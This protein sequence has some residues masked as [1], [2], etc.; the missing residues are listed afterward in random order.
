MLNLKNAPFLLICLGAFLLL[1][2]GNGQCSGYFVSLTDTQGKAL[3]FTKP[4]RK[5]VCLFPAV[6]EMMVRFGKQETLVGLC[7]QDMLEHS[8]LTVKNLGSFFSPD[9]EAIAR[10]EPDLI[11]AFPSQKDVIQRVDSGDCPV[12]VMEIRSLDQSFSVMGDMGRLFD[13]EQKARDVIEENKNQIALVKARLTAEPE[14]KR[15]RVVR[16]MMGQAL[17]CPGDD[18]FQNEVIRAA[19]GIPPQ[20]GRN[21]FAVSVSPEEWTT[22]DPEFV[23]GCDRNQKAVEALL[24]K[25]P[26][27]RVAAVKNGSVSMFPCDLTCRATVRTGA[28]VQWFATTLYPDL[29]TDPHKAV[30]QDTFLSKQPLN[31]P[32]DYVKEASVVTHRVWDATYHSVLINLS[33]PMVVLS[34]FEGLR[35]GVRGVGNTHVPMHASLGHMMHGVDAVKPVIARNLGFKEKHYAGL[36]TGA[37]MDNLSIQTRTSGDL[38]V[39]LLVTAGVRGNALRV[40]EEFQAHDT[41]GTINVIVLTNRHLSPSAMA[42]AMVMVTEGKTAALSDMDIRS[43]RTP[44]EHQATGT[45]TDTILVVEGQ[46][47]EILWAGGHTAMG[48]MIAGAAYD[49]VVEAIFKQ[50]GIRKNR[51]ILQRLDERKLTLENLAGMFDA[52]MEKTMLAG[53]LETLLAQ[54]FYASFVE[55]ALSLDDALRQGQIQDTSCFDILCKDLV[56]RISGTP[57]TET[58][59][60]PDIPLP[61]M[62]ARAFSALVT[63]IFER[64]AQRRQP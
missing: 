7:R 56:S 47:K 32:L 19:G 42:W 41:P 34:T 43:T 63:G 59:I 39:T 54:P 25:E 20:W 48:Q 5:V 11:I 1:M 8:G 64:D 13:C 29:F 28:F 9:T 22:F 18:S 52:P 14:L 38:T 62:T 16:V 55:M 35:S 6:T 50:N 17:S 15:K 30:T 44:L 23:Y 37:S 53:R 40:A 61:P 57:G 3:K 26:Y 27:N 4:P 24:N 12:M 49:G 36:M 58:P 21:G 10:C 45:G 46:G 2:P 51:N 31:I 60:T 33:K